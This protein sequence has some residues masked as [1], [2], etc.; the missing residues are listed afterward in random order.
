M[1][2][3]SMHTKTAFDA[4]RPQHSANIV[5]DQDVH[6]WVTA[7]F[8]REMTG[9]EGH[10]DFENVESKFKFTRCICQGD[11]GAPTR[12][13]SNWQCRF[14]RTWKQNREKGWEFILTHVKV[15]AVKSAALCSPIIIGLC[16]TEICTWS[17]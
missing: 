1:Y 7:A 6:G 2:I 14:H 3:G 4:A 9:L 15:E 12:F 13:G 16:H 5:D 17:R 8:L 11:V 10:T